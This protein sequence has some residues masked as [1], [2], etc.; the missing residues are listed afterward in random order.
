MKALKILGVVV[1][2]IIVILLVVAAFLPSEVRIEK[3]TVMK[4]PAQ[5]VFDQINCMK[6]WSAWSPWELAD[7]DMK[8]TYEGPEC[9]EGSKHLW[10][11]P[12][13][14]KGAQTITLSKPC[15]RID[16]ELDFY[17][18]GKAQAY[19]TFKEENGSTTVSWGFVSSD[20]KYPLDRLFGQM[21][22]QMLQKSYIDGLNNLKAL[23][24]KD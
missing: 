21:M 17:E 19:W 13:S 18:G 22:K 20:L 16:T 2:A 6:N 10:N 24:E 12:K 15:S 4:A 11:G 7:P 3:T 9:G 1:L 5:E 23:V 14:G 8:S